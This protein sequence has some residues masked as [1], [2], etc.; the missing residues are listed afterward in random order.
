MYSFPIF[1]NNT[2][3]ARVVGV[4]FAAAAAAAASVRRASQQVGE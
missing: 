1:G 2:L 3:A 4:L